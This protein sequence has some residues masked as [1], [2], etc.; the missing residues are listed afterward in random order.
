[1]HANFRLQVTMYWRASYAESSGGRHAESYRHLLWQANRKPCTHP[2]HKG[3]AKKTM[4]NDKHPHEDLYGQ[5]AG[6]ATRLIAWI[7]DQLIISAILA[8]FTWIVTFVTDTFSINEFLGLQEWADL[9]V[10]V[11]IVLGTLVIGFSY[12]VG[13]WLLAGQTPGKRAM[14]L[15]VV[16]TNGQR[17]TFWAATV[18]WL[19]YAVTA[20]LFLGYLWVLVD[21]RRQGFHDKLARTFVIYAWPER[22]EWDIAPAMRQRQALRSQRQNADGTETPA[23][24]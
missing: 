7:V 1:M 5:Y 21:N 17:L 23:A 12:Q 8:V 19:S 20:I 24:D 3:G 22:Q 9:I 6:F 4:T 10:V 2:T 15:R 16:R 18:R 14:G 13:F 11:I